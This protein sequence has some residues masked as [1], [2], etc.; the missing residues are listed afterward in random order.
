MRVENFGKGM[1]T[2]L[3]KEIRQLLSDESIRERVLMCSNLEME[4]L[5][6]FRADLA[7]DVGHLERIRDGLHAELAA[8]DGLIDTRTGENTDSKSEQYTIR[9]Q[10]EVA[11]AEKSRL[12]SRIAD[13]EAKIRSFES[14]SP[15]LY[16]TLNQ[17]DERLKESLSNTRLTMSEI[18]ASIIEL[19]RQVAI[20]THATIHCTQ[21]RDHEVRELSLPT[22]IH[23]AYESIKLLPSK[24]HE[25]ETRTLRLLRER[26]EAAAI[27]QNIEIQCS[28]AH[29]RLERACM[30]NKQSQKL[31]ETTIS[32][33]REAKVENHSLSARVTRNHA[34]IERLRRTNQDVKISIGEAQDRVDNLTKVQGEQFLKLRL[35]DLN[36]GNG[37]AISQRVA[38]L[39]RSVSEQASALR[40]LIEAQH[41]TKL[42]LHEESAR[43]QAELSCTR[44]DTEQLKEERDRLQL[45]V[46]EGLEKLQSLRESIMESQKTIENVKSSTVSFSADELE[47]SNEKSLLRNETEELNQFLLQSQATAAELR[48]VLRETDE[49]RCTVQNI[50]SQIES[51]TQKSNTHPWTVKMVISPRLRQELEKLLVLQRALIVSQRDHFD[52]AHTFKLKQSCLTKRPD[53]RELVDISDLIIKYRRQKVELDSSERNLAKLHAASDRLEER[54]HDL[55]QQLALTENQPSKTYVA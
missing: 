16:E 40:C 54:I 5:D 46:H 50:E 22:E 21:S 37:K 32:A 24:T 20:P 41:D 38:A 2:S 27:L 1:K 53:L 25:A 8:I 28:V 29:D 3:L 43:V 7:S 18:D 12:S 45:V 33:V 23:R 6:G 34:V 13:L 9:S 4:I 15:E 39:N 49:E 36:T 51:I 10:F 31:L 35:L 14:Y 47:I 19:S 11:I 44:T 30:K 17:E 42:K 26:D 55:Q 48:Q 52:L